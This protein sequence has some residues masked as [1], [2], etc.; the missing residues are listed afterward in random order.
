MKTEEGSL[1]EGKVKIKL[2]D[3][4]TILEVDED[5]IEKV[6]ERWLQMVNGSALGGICSDSRAPLYSLIHT[7][8]PYQFNAFIARY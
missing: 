3:D 7:V 8:H 5:D 2:E 6:N 1:P 4:G